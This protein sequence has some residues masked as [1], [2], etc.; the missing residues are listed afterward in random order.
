MSCITPLVKKCQRVMNIQ[1]VLPF[2]QQTV[3]TSYAEPVESRQRPHTLLNIHFNIIV[4][5]TLMSHGVYSF[6]VYKLQLYGPTH[7]SPPYA[8]YMSRPSS[9]R[10]FNLRNDI[11]WQ[12]RYKICGSIFGLTFWN[13][14]T[15]ICR[16]T[17][18]TSRRYILNIYSTNIHTAYFKH[19]A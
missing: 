19:A 1:V 5:S 4:S 15:Y 13:L 16:T 10:W 7:F 14:T 18:L 8:C 11:T 6:Q 12:V 3:T 9:I 2:S 17:A